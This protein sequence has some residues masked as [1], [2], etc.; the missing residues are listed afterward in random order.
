MQWRK[1]STRSWSANFR[2]IPA[3]RMHHQGDAHS[4]GARESKGAEDTC[5][6]YWWGLNL[7]LQYTAKTSC[8]QLRATAIFLTFDR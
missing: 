4:A 8:I 7:L 5:C 2:W 6:G 1:R 3:R